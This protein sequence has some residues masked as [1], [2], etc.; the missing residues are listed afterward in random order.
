MATISALCT[1]RSTSETTQ[2][3]FGKT[4]FHSLN[5]RFNAESIVMR[6]PESERPAFHAFDRLIHRIKEEPLVRE[7]IS[8]SLARKRPERSEGGVTASRASSLIDGSARV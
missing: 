8:L 6:T 3:A 2:A 4:S 1:R 5:A 7:A